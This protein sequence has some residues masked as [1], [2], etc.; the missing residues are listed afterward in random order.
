MTP[1]TVR[2]PELM[3]RTLEK[4]ADTH[5][6]TVSEVIRDGVNMAI[7]RDMMGRYPHA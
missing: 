2:M 3:W 6:L 7:V 1:R 4:I 5:G